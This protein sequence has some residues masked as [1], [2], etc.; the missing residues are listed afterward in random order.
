MQKD[1]ALTPFIGKRCMGLASPTGNGCLPPPIRPLCTHYDSEGQGRPSTPTIDARF[2]AITLLPV[3]SA[4]TT[5]HTQCMRGTWR[6]VCGT[7][8]K[9]NDSFRPVIVGQEESA[10]HDPSSSATLRTTREEIGN[11]PKI[12]TNEAAKETL[13]GQPLQRFFLCTY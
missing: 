6:S 3:S 11:R 1:T 2:S 12:K 5:Y 9:W 4:S 8:G 13:R 7:G 10:G